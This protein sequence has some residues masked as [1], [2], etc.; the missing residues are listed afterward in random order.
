MFQRIYQPWRYSVII[1]LQGRRILHNYLKQKITRLWKPTE[2]FPLIDLCNDYYTV[3]FQKEE[4][5]YDASNEGSVESPTSLCPSPTPKP[6]NRSPLLSSRSYDK[7]Q[8]HLHAMWCSDQPCSPT[9]QSTS[10]TSLPT[11]PSFISTLS[12]RT[13]SRTRRANDGK[14]GKSP[15]S[16]TVGCRIFK[17]KRSKS[18]HLHGDARLEEDSQMSSDTL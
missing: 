2:N 5:K 17:P 12:L 4:P 1:K 16:T 14:I 3:K 11:Q 8:S 9:E 13:S 15:S 10:S 7:P 18:L 6:N